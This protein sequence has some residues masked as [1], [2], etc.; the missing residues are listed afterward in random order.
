MDTLRI[1]LTGFGIGIASSF[2]EWLLIG[3]LFHKYQDETPATWR[4]ESPVS[5]ILS[6]LLAVLF[7]LLFAFFYD[8]VGR[9]FAAGDMMRA[10]KLG[11]LCCVAFTITSELSSAIYV[12]W[13]WRFILGK[14]IS[15]IVV[16]TIAGIIAFL[17]L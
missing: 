1:L 15:S 14:L 13:S 7:G 4:K 11:L 2:A 10:I 16:Y 3:K 9:D 5:Y 17:F 8:R 12:Q 6:S